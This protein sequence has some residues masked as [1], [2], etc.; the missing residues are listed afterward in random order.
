M[1]LKKSYKIC[2]DSTL[3]LQQDMSEIMMKAAFNLIKW[4][5]N[6]E[7]VMEAIDSAKRAS[8]PFEEFNSSDPLKALGVSWDLNSDHFAD[9]SHRM[10]SSHDPNPTLVRVFLCPCVG[11]FP[12]VGQTLTWFIWGRYLALHITL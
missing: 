7:L 4:I 2:M 6:S 8:S 9:S 5:S 11:P 10:E 12:S 1:Q 3:K